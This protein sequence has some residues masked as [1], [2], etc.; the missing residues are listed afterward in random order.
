MAA[1]LALGGAACAKGTSVGGD[2]TYTP[3]KPS[4][5]P[6]VK[7]SKTASTK[8]TATKSSS[9]PP[10]GPKAKDRDVAAVNGN[11]FD[12]YDV[13][14]AVGDTVIFTNK[15]SD[16]TQHGIVVEGTDID[17]GPVSP[18][19]KFEFVVKLAP[20]TYDFKCAVVP[21]MVGGKLIVN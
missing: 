1:A 12:P 17:S 10:A 9:K 14:A 20:D 21:Y 3:P 13:Q 16:G 8:P 18:G 19:D 15:V 2:A 5:S 7:P 6:K 4:K 11:V